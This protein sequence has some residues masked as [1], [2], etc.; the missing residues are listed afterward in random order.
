MYIYT[1]LIPNFRHTFHLNS[2]MDLSP[3]LGKTWYFFNIKTVREEDCNVDWERKKLSNNLTI[4]YENWDHVI[5]ECLHKLT[6]SLITISQKNMRKQLKIFEIFSQF[7]CSIL[8]SFSVFCLFHTL[9]SFKFLHTRSSFDVW[10]VRHS[11]IELSS[12]TQ[13]SWLN[14]QDWTQRVD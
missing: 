8:T 4:L 12:S 13:S 1:V 5:F 9:F 2:R 3:T 14:V 11:R 10:Q 6:L 7:V